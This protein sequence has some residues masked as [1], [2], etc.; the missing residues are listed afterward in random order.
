[1]ICHAVN[2]VGGRRG[3]APPLDA[4]L[5]ATR[6]NPFEFAAR[7]WAGAEDMIA[8]QKEDF[9]YRVDITAK[10]LAD[11]FAFVHDEEEQKLFVIPGRP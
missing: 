1:M 9:N 7:M 11:I 10:E 3:T 5:M 8:L 2:S 4:A 6:P